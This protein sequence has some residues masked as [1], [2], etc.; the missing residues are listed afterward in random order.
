MMRRMFAVIITGAPGAGKSSALTALT[1]MLGDDEVPHVTVELDDLARGWPWRRPPAAYESLA[2]FVAVQRT[3]LLLTSAT[4]TS[5]AELAGFLASVGCQ[6]HLLVRLHARPETLR[7][8]IRERETVPWSGL[9]ALIGRTEALQ[10][11]IAALPGVHLSLDSEHATPLELA[12]A[13]CARLH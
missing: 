8:R 11:Q 3:E 1:D 4:I 5:A 6:D 12:T 13:I 7:R 9:E 10:E 2:A